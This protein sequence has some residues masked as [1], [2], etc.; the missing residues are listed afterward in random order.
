M[1]VYVL[2]AILR[3]RLGLDVSLYSLLQVL[4]IGLFEKSP[5]LQAFQH[6]EPTNESND[7]S[8]QLN[9]FDF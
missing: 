5:I 3:K 2:V 6:I 4:S 7:V 1:A 8:N 9:L